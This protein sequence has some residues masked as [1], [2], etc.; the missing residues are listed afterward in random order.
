MK[1][2]SILILSL[3]LT[4]VT[5]SQL[6]GTDL[7][8]AVD[9][10]GNYYHDY[11]QTLVMKIGISYPD[12][13]G[14]S[15]VLNTFED[16]LEIIKTSDKLSLGVSKII[17]LVG[18]Q[19]NGHDDKYPAFFEVNNALKRKEDASARES[20]RWL[21][22]EAR[23]YNTT[24]SLHINMTDA[25]DNSPLWEEYL[26]KDLISKTPHGIPMVIGVWNDRKAYQINYRNEWKK[27]YTQMRIDRL[28]QLIPELQE[29]K[30]IHIDAWIA[31]ESKGH[32]ESAVTEAKYQ[33]RA[34][35]YWNAKGMDVTSEWV[36]DYMIGKVPF[37][38]H[39][40]AFS[41][42]NYQKYPARVYTGSGLNPDVN[43]TDF[44][45]GFLFGKSMYGETVFP[46]L[47][48]NNPK[49]NKNWTSAFAKDF[50]SNCLQY[51]YLN[52]LERLR[53]NGEGE[54]RVAHFSGDVRVSLGDSTVMKGD[55]LLRD[56]DFV[57]FP[58]VWKKEK[59]LALFSQSE[60]ERIIQI[61]VTWGKIND[62]NIYQV[63][64]DGEKFL[65]SSRVNNG[66]FS[67][68]MKKEVPYLVKVD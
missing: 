10:A 18:W 11:S 40:N 36:M 1:T 46:A 50:Y 56:K 3:S 49:R 67:L 27:G 58:P 64:T 38:W 68:A 9:E 12:G 62:I 45:L 52:K 26:E 24:V 60:S 6:R 5:F 13:K 47:Q 17:Y 41:Q 54:G 39:F 14:G 65:K 23:K 35:E 63:T 31:R 57:C 43:G 48:Q 28:L 20:L 19:Y 33:Q 8:D 4:G 7:K 59:C 42:E 34:L 55:Y 51:F 25:Y 16:A 32:Y 66:S 53:V 15:V 22:R 61:P 29:A 2:I 37:A 21:M 30:T 44:G